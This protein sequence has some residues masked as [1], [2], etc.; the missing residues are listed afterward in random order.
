[1]QRRD[2]I[3]LLGGAATWPLAARA[4]QPTA[5]AAL[6]YLDSGAS[7]FDVFPGRH[8]AF[9]QSLSDA[10]FI[11]GRNLAIEYRWAEGH[12][13]RLAALAA[14]LV[15]RPVAAIFANGVAAALAAKEATRTIPIIFATGGDPVQLGLVASFNRPGSNL[16]GVT[17]IGNVLLPKQL[18]VLHELAPTAD[19]V[20]FLVDPANPNSEF[21]TKNLEAAADVAGQ[22]ILT[23]SATSVREIDAAFTSIAQRRTVVLLVQTDPLFNS[24]RDQIAALALRHAVPAMA[25]YR[26]FAL[27]GGLA[28]YGADTD[29]GRRMAGAYVGRILKGEKPG[30]LPVFQLSKLEL[31]INL[32]TAKAIDLTVPPLL[33]ARA[34]KVI[35]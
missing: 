12:N 22:K 20:A 3:T 8:A 13:E 33:T 24:R 10:G 16:T 5:A 18:E 34:D 4:Q 9:R 28:S 21:D 1:M 7:D 29:E 2:F 15:H 25:S 23:V 27:A 32:T 30:D 35:E 19:T 14:E 6:G 17:V 26:E 11:L 31:V